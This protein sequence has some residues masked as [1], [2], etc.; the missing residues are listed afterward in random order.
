ML[1]EPMLSRPGPIPTVRGWRFEVNFPGGLVLDW[2]LV[3]FKRGV[4]H[5]PLLTR[6]RLNGERSIAVTFMAFDLLKLDGQSLVASPFAARSG[7]PVDLVG[8]P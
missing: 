6:R 2:E 3:A 1:P 4:P 8:R 5:F 7:P